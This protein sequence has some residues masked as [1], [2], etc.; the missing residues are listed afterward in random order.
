M[1]LQRQFTMT[2][3]SPIN[4][5][6][7]S[8]EDAIRTL[9][10][11]QSSRQQSLEQ[12]HLRQQSFA[13]VRHLPSTARSAVPVLAL[14]AFLLL[15]L[16][17]QVFGEPY[18]ERRVTP[19][20]HKPA[21][22]EVWNRT[23]SSLRSTIE[24]RPNVEVATHDIG[25][26]Q[27]GHT[28]LGQ[29]GTG[30]VGNIVDPVTGEQ[31]PSATF[32]ANSG[33]N[34]LYIAALW[35]GA[36]VGRDTL[37][38][39]GADDGFTV[40]EFWPG[41]R[42][43]IEHRSIIPG[44]LFESDD[45]ISEQDLVA[46]Y[47]DTLDDAGQTAQDPID[48]RP[49]VPL[50]LKIEER[51]L[52]WSYDYA[53]DFILFDYSIVN[54]G[55]RRL[56]KLYMGIY[57]DG[58]VHH[59]SKQGLDAFGDDICGFRETLPADCG[60]LDTI[61]MAYIMDNDGDPVDNAWDN[62]TSIR[63]VAGVRLIR[64]PSDSLEYS[65]NW[66]SASPGPDFGPRRSGTDEKPFRDMNGI[67]GAPLG[68]RN[69]Y[70]MLSNGEFDYDQLFTAVD[71][72]SAG[73]L[74]P[75]KQATS[76][77]QGGDPKFMLSFGPFQVFPGE[78]L[79]ITFAYI[80]GR[81]FHT[82]PTDFDD[83]LRPNPF[84]PEEFANSLNFSDFG[85]NSNWASWIY[86]N[87]CVDTDDDGYSGALRI[88]VL[89]DTF[90]VESALVIDSSL[91][92]P[93]TLM[94]IDTALDTLLSDT[95]CSGDGVPDFRGA[96]PPPA[97]QLR[98]IPDVGKLTL[99]WNGY[100]S[101]NT[102][103]PFSGEIDFEG[104]RVYTSRIRQTSQFVMTTSY[105]IEDYNRFELNEISGEF[106]LTASPFS[107][108]ELRALY[109]PSFDPLVFGIDNPFLFTNPSNGKTS[110]FYFT[111]QD[112][113]QSELLSA[114]DFP[115]PGFIR[116]RFDVPKPS[117]NPDEWTESD[118][119]SEGQPK[120]YEYEI[121]L[122]NLLPSVPLYVSVTAFDFGSPESGLSS[123]E[124]NPLLNTVQE[125]PL[126]SSDEAQKQGLDVVVYPNPYRVDGNYR[127]N[128]FEGLE[129]SD[130]PDE[131]TRAVHFINLPR[132]CD[133][134]IY[135]LDGDLLRTIEHRFPQGGPGSMHEQWDLITRN[136]QVTVSGI[137]YYV[138]E[139]PDG[140]TQIGKLVI[141]F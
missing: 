42:D 77:V 61:N 85:L 45:A 22:G 16:A 38:S 92:P 62:T 60:F 59:Q 136:L 110:T 108:Q 138:V 137:Y 53:G 113:N 52:Q 91:S 120:Y 107:L 131:R 135:S 4:Q 43:I 121:T 12:R 102:P 94:V 140:A 6:G 128:G 1:T 126:L 84:Q 17:S 51:S 103:D 40:H 100:D 130:L 28:N 50:Q 21:P 10:K 69:K 47:Y 64:T 70:F 134:H 18:S 54:I 115:R 88:C 98:V 41:A 48:G 58:D 67:L 20:D 133:I 114:N 87:P 26:L 56:D 116:K 49:H 86:D 76:L 31:I 95:T 24:D 14:V 15:P 25:Q 65:F 44:N 8:A 32:P 104:Y 73:W 97:P 90:V 93:E 68:D 101:E 29:F 83:L 63:S 34:H 27:V 129:D 11:T 37:V 55:R 125:F 118:T 35:I 106:E 2:G 46:T 5:S 36:V 30:F 66:W 141:I 81:N 139:T 78:T 105:D 23:S 109:G 124:S 117:S 132:V 9:T 72:S 71:H 33:L 75:P 119:T 74:P 3:Y 57:V 112:W 19:P 96:A 80:A 13:S 123:L 82:K 99:R 111:R 122:D 79:P 127:T 7:N 39:S 89:Q